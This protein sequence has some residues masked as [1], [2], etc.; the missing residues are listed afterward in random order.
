MQTATP[1]VQVVNAVE[2]QIGE[3]DQPDEAPAHPPPHPPQQPPVPPPHALQMAEAHWPEAARLVHPTR[4]GKWSLLAQN[5]SIQA[6]V[7]DSI[8]LVLCHVVS[9]DSFPSGGDKAKLVQ[10]CLYQA[11]EAEGFT[12]IT[13]RLSQDRNFGRWL[14]SLVR[15]LFLVLFPSLIQLALA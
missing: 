5:L 1:N 13:D 4:G 8:P 7:Q 10:D 12:D 14:S 11:A 3:P 9:F 6:V 2:D 15:T